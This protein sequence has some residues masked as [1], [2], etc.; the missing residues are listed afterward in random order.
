MSQLRSVCCLLP[1]ALLVSCAFASQCPPPGF[2]TQGALEGGFDLKWYTSSKWFTQQQMVTTYL[3]ADYFRCVSAEYTLLDERTLLGYDVKVENHAENQEGKALGPL[4]TLCAKV[5]NSTA[6]KLLVS[7]CFLPSFAAGDYW[8][9]AFDKEAGWALVSG[10]APSKEGTDGCQ[11]GTGVN[12]SGLWIFTRKQERDEGLVQKIRAVA[13]K[14]GFDVS[15]LKD[16]DQTNC[17]SS[18]TSVVHV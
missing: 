18:D 3:P 17:K 6:G 14:K 4:T 7:P 1:S 5:V 11:T 16:T 9:E 12:G 15:V 2:D 8:V 10:G 13:V